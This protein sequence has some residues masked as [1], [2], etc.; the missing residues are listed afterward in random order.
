MKNEETK[1]EAEIRVIS[2]E[3]NPYSKNCNNQ[4]LWSEGY[5][6]A[7]SDFKEKHSKMINLL[8]RATILVGHPCTNI[9]SG[10]DI[11]CDE[12]QK[13]CASFL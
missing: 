6:A 4:H 10:T 7:C 1:T 11:A 12:W 3:K 8:E 13:D 9:S 2:E 5:R